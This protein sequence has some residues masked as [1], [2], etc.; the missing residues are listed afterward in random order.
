[1]YD[2]LECEFELQKSNHCVSLCFVSLSCSPTS[3]YLGVLIVC[4]G[5]ITLLVIIYQNHS[6]S[7]VHARSQEEL[8]L[9]LQVLYMFH[10]SDR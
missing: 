3:I 2:S 1:M 9:F 5:I 4:V 7:L 6:P 8:E 10:Q